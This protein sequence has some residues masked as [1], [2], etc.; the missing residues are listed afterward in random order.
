MEL[1]INRWGNSLALRLP[2]KILKQMHLQE[3]SKVQVEL[4]DDGRLLVQPSLQMPALASRAQIIAELEAMHKDWP[5][6]RS[7][8]RFMRD[9]GY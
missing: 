6:G 9:G 5:M 3:G 7:V 4:S 8:I 2:N 1:Q